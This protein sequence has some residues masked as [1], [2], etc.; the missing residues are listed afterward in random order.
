M[1]IAGLTVLIVE[2]EP[3]IGLVLEDLV[4]DAGARP[5][6]ASTVAHAL[7][8]LEENTVDAA[9]LDVNVHGEKSYPV[10]Q[11]LMA[12]GTRFVF[13]SGYGDALHPEEFK[14]VPTITKPYAMKEIVEGLSR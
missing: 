10:A 13:A 1:S 6:L 12:Q 8:A 14:A 7:K 4:L 9:V 2:D 3:I 5:L 11:A